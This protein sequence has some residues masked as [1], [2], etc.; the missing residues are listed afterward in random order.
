MR[1]V[2]VTAMWLCSAALPSH[3]QEQGSSARTQDSLLATYEQALL[4]LR[5][6]TVPVRSATSQFQRD[7][8]L[9]GEVTVISRAARLNQ[10]CATLQSSLE[11]AEPVFRPSRAPSGRAREASRTFLDEMEVLERALD[12]HC[13]DGLPQDGPGVWADSLRAWGPFHTANLQRVL[14]SYDGAAFVFAQAVG[15]RLEPGRTGIVP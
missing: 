11:A 13:L 2:F 1:S 5:D 12:T 6:S 9:A 7:L 10:A 8:Q 14:Q 15:V 3:G 4:A